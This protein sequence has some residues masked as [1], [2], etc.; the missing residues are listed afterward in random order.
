MHSLFR[1]LLVFIVLLIYTKLQNIT[2]NISFTFL[3]HA[4]IL[5]NAFFFVKIPKPLRIKPNVDDSVTLRGHNWVHFAH[6]L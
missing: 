1:N 6:R 4:Y 2:S 5:F 3:K